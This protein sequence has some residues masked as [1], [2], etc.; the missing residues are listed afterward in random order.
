ME[1]LQGAVVGGNIAECVRLLNAGTPADY[2]VKRKGRVSGTPL[3]DQDVER[4]VPVLFEAVITNDAEICHLLLDRGADPNRRDSLGRTALHIA[5]DPQRL[6]AL[7]VLIQHGAHLNV[8]DNRKTSPLHYAV[9]KKCPEA[10]RAL[11]EAGA[12]VNAPGC[13]ITPVYITALHGTAAVMRVLLDYGAPPESALFTPHADVIMAVVLHDGFTPTNETF[14]ELMRAAEHFMEA[15][16][17]FLRTN[18]DTIVP[19]SGEPDV[20]TP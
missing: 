8:L 2:L 6:A 5:A 12:D 3:V 15:W 13:E 16:A 4:D 1:A 10:C 7:G 14:R 9:G 17:T 20:I 18:I 11:L 19:A